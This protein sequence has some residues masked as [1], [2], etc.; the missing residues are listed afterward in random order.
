M[1]IHFCEGPTLKERTSKVNLFGASTF[2]LPFLAILL[3]PRYRSNEHV[4]Y[5][6]TYNSHSVPYNMEERRVTMA[7][8]IWGHCGLSL[9]GFQLS[10]DM[11]ELSAGNSSISHG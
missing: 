10:Y 8:I 2:C 3:N 7:H 6:V 9:G 1:K 4:G 5:Y 11:D